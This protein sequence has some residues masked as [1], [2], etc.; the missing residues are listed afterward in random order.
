MPARMPRCLVAALL[1]LAASA[2]SPASEVDPGTCP[3][4]VRRFGVA[5]G[6]GAQRG[7]TAVGRADGRPLVAVFADQAADEGVWAWSC[8]DPLCAGGAL[9]FLG[10]FG[11]LQGH[12][13]V[14][15]RANGRPLVFAEGDFRLE[16]F[17]CEDVDCRSSRRSPVAG[18]SLLDRG[19]EGFLGADALPRL[20]AGTSA[21]TGLVMYACA[22]AECSSATR[23]TIESGQGAGA[24]DSP[25]LARGPQGQ[26]VVLHRADLGAGYRY[27]I[28]V[29]SDGDCTVARYLT[30]VLPPAAVVSDVAMRA[31][32]RLVMVETEFTG[33]VHQSR[34]RTCVDADCASSEVMPLFTGAFAFS[35]RID[36]A[37]RPLIGYGGQPFGMVACTSASCIGRTLR[38]MGIAGP[39]GGAFTRLALSAGGQ[40]LVAVADRSG[41]P[42][43]L[44][45]CDPDRILRDGFEPAD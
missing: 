42:P 21:G 37:G 24:Y 32:G 33:S 38:P 28:L 1:M 13:V 26:V 29:C 19:F 16:R 39:N 35:M 23:R 7:I 2:A 43:R 17:D 36:P 30:P 5:E 6:L 41:G 25:T 4:D 45:L 31:D 44:G 27:G 3:I 20:V 10:A 34:L 22:T 40:P 14:L 12:P 18:Y 8:N 11:F 9:T 15:L